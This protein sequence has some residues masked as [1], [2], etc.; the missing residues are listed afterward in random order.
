MTSITIYDGAQTIGGN[1]IFVEEGGRG[2]FLDFGKN[3]G[4]YSRYYEEFLKNRDTR[5]IHDLHYLNL[6][7]KLNNYRPDLI[8]AD[9]S[10]NQYPKLDIAAVLLSHAHLD[11]CGNIGL[12]DNSIPIV[13]SPMSIAILKGM[14]DLAKSSVDGDT[15]YISEREPCNSDALVLKAG[16]SKQPYVGKDFYATEEILATLSAFLTRKPGQ[17]AKKTKKLSPGLLDS[18]KK[19]I[20]SKD[21]LR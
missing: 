18:Y 21:R 4:K 16:G 3:F 19:L 1:K 12:L 10:L 17:E 7:P 6:I 5:G 8:P 20:V 15:C 9:V 14:Q 11:H 2:V 13:A